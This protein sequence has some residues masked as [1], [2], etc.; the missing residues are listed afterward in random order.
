MWRSMLRLV[1]AP[2]R[3][4]SAAGLVRHHHTIRSTQMLMDFINGKTAKDE[5][6]GPFS[7]TP[8]SVSA[9]LESK[10][11]SSPYYRIGA[12][13]A[14]SSSGSIQDTL[15]S[16]THASD[17][18]GYH[19]N[20]Q[21]LTDEESVLSLLLHCMISAVDPR[22]KN[23]PAET[24]ALSFRGG[25]RPV[26]LSVAKSTLEAF[27]FRQHWPAISS[28]ESTLIA[29]Q[30]LKQKLNQTRGWQTAAQSDDD[31]LNWINSIFAPTLYRSVYALKNVSK[32]PV[33]VIYDILLRQPQNRQEFY[34]LLELYRHWGQDVAL[35]DQ[36]KWWYCSQLQ[37]PTD[38]LFNRKLLLPPAFS[39]LYLFALREAPE[40]LETILD[41]FLL[42]NSPELVPQIRE[43]LW[44]TALDVSGEN[45][46]WPCKHYYAAQSKLIAAINKANRESESDLI[47]CNIM[48]AASVVSYF[49]DR[50]KAYQLFKAA[51]AKF[52]RWQLDSFDIDGFERVLS[53]PRSSPSHTIEE[54]RRLRT[55]FNVKSLCTSILLIQAQDGRYWGSEF[56]DQLVSLM[57]SLD[58]KLRDRY[59]EI[60]LFVIYKIFTTNVSLNRHQKIWNHFAARGSSDPNPRAVDILIDNIP[61][62]S[63]VEQLLEA[64]DFALDNINLAHFV[65]KLYLFS[66]LRVP[67]RKVGPVREKN[68]VDRYER[69]CDTI[70]E[71][72]A[73]RQNLSVG[74][75]ETPV[76]L[77]RALFEQDH[78]SRQMVAKHL[79]GE[80]LIDPAGAH[81]RY[82]Q[83]L[84]DN[85]PLALSSLFLAAL[86]LRELRT[87]DSVVWDDKTP[88]DFAIQEFDLRT[89]RAYKDNPDLM[90]PTENLLLVYIKALGEFERRAEL[91][92]LIWRLVDLRFPMIAELFEAYLSYFSES[93]AKQLVHGLNQYAEYRA[94]LA[95]VRTEGELARLNQS[96]P[97][98]FSD[99]SFSKFLDALDINWDIIKWWEWPEKSQT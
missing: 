74:V 25:V 57:A 30:L 16:L 37:E 73:S 3:R 40:A 82:Q 66:K 79:V 33:P 23:A 75:F 19:K 69:E 41:V 88:L 80:C 62:R 95:D 97:V 65:A 28:S 48:L 59:P 67:R 98:E 20:L 10:Y 29:F 63:S 77:A 52:D 56:A 14:S 46:G 35:L 85:S 26:P 43:I 34:S 72:R 58:S 13:L 87:Y 21:K 49:S 94:S 42:S 50:D 36:E 81:T 17:N 70:I 76:E 1:S 54:L 12:S 39:N 11:S 9:I 51:Q 18:T 8:R 71:E 5:P 32:V 83:F 64:G 92:S 91:T 15:L 93:D 47:D 7:E 45:N 27:V 96:R 90:Y 61:S 86:R 31:V 53:Q 24:L 89:N 60:W 68:L 99:G 38:P 44:R 4:T 22:Y 6:K 78:S 55:D 2:L 84:D